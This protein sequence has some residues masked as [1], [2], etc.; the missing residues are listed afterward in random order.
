MNDAAAQRQ[1]SAAV[2]VLRLLA[3]AFSQHN[4]AAVGRLAPSGS[5]AAAP[6]PP[7]WAPAA[8]ELL[9]SLTE[10]G[11]ARPGQS[12]LPQLAGR[13]AA[14]AL[15]AGDPEAVTALLHELLGVDM[16]PDLIAITEVMRAWN[17]ARQSAP[18]CAAQNCPRLGRPRTQ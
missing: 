16:R 4:V 5:A 2:G 12:S 8:G 9:L 7:A 13:L 1:L 17:A 14:D 18:A 15:A 11:A 3:A 10:A 6:Q